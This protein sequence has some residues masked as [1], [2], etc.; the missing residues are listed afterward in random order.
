[1]VIASAGRHWSKVLPLLCVA[2]G[3]VV[4]PCCFSSVPP[5]TSPASSGGGGSIRASSGSGAMAMTFKNYELTGSW[6]ELKAA[7]ATRPG[8]LTY[9][10][11]VVDQ[12]FYAESCAIADYNHDG[13]PD[14]S[15]GRRWWEGPAFTKVHIFRGGHDALPRTGMNSETT[16]C[17]DG[18][19]SND[20]IITGVSDDWADYPWDMDGDGW[21]DIIDIASCDANTPASPAPRP[22]SAGSGYWYKNPGPA[23]AGD[24]MWA[25]YQ[26]HADMKLEHK[27]LFDVNGDGKPEIFA[28]CKD[29]PPGQTKGYFQADWSHPTA[30][31]T[32]HPVTRPYVFPFGGTGWM[33]GLGAGDINGDGK[34]DLLE[35]SGIWLQPDSPTAAWHWIAV[36]LSDTPAQD[37][38]GHHG[39]SHM[40][41]FDINGDGLADVVSTDWAHGYGLAWYEQV[42]PATAGADPTF[43]KHYIFNTESAADVALYKVAF[44]QPHAMQFVDMDGDGLPDIVIGKMHFAHP[45][46]ISDPDTLG[47]PVLYVFKLVR[48]PSAPGGARF[49]PHLVDDVFGVGRQVTVGHI[50]TDGIMDICV[51]SKLGLAVFLGQ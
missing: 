40:F 24:P 3:G 43:I 29:C 34:P 33:H 44:S 8:K 13:N 42:K 45:I 49:E 48:D 12:N 4:C 27:G 1:M 5:R 10:K 21:T 6:P 37:N 30:A 25:S 19:C 31:W 38:T 50:N 22:Q 16:Y 47:K 17:L 39:G 32:F 9:T 18:V 51:S 41:S 2:A 28:A 23:L 46:A 20:E 11:Q 26:I 36:S 7:I 35:R 15:A 14:I